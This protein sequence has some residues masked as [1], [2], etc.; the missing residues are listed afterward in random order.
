MS[1]VVLALPKKL[2]SQPE[3]ALSPECTSQMSRIYPNNVASVVGSAN[4]IGT[5]IQ[6]GTTAGAFPVQ[7]VRFSVPA[8]MGKHVFIDTTKSRL[9]FR[10]KYTTTVSVTNSD[11]AGYLVSSAYSWWDRIQTINNNGQAIDDVVNLGQIMNQRTIYDFNSSDR[12]SQWQYGFLSE[13]AGNQAENDLQGHALELLTKT[14]A[15]L[16]ATT[17]SFDYSIPLPSSLL[18]LGARNFCPIGALTSLGISLWTPSTVPVVYANTVATTSGTLQCTIDNISIDFQYI[19]LDAKSASL[20][21][22]GKEYYIHSITHRLSTGYI[23]TAAGQVSTLIGL[24]GRSV[25]ALFAKF[26]ESVQSLAASP[27]GVYDSKL[28]ECTQLNFFLGGKDRFPNVTHN[29]L[30]APSTVYEHTQQ[31]MEAFSPDKTKFGGT[32]N[33]YCRAFAGVN[34]TSGESRWIAQAGSTSSLKALG[35]FNLGEDLRVAS[36]SVILDGYDMS[37]SASHFLEMN[38]VTAPTNN[39]NISFISAQDIIYVVDLM[40]GNIEARV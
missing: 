11:W 24:R 12:D 29:S 36:S 15:L 6:T 9:N 25:R 19:Y 37:Q 4:S 35:T 18:G 2:Q 33:T 7:E 40:T 17:Q 20:L 22:L 39:I 10:V 26:S 21:N 31:A 5:A 30:Y 14:G 3:G 8:G 23:A 16:T 38:I 13:S 27:A 32:Y 1:S 28:L 34:G